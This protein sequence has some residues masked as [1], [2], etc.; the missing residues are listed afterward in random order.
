MKIRTCSADAGD[1]PIQPVDPVTV[2][3]NCAYS[4]T[5]VLINDPSA[6]EFEVETFI[7]CTA[8][9]SSLITDQVRDTL[10]SSRP[11]KTPG[12]GNAMNTGSVMK[13]IENDIELSPRLLLA[14]KP[15][16]RIRRKTRA[17]SKG[18]DYIRS[19][20]TGNLV[21]ND[22]KSSDS[23]SSERD[24]LVILRRRLLQSLL[25]RRSS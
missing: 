14:S 22:M 25:L 21:R 13:V 17:L 7:S 1:S 15:E 5:D 18:T 6:L 9:Q 10:N 23:F 19:S 12:D 16:P 8:T 11:S 3:K 20:S 4:R 2:S 24:L